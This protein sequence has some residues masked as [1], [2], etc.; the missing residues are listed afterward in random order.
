MDL[1]DDQ[2]AALVI[3]DI[4]DETDDEIAEALAGDLETVERWCTALGHHMN[5]LNG[6]F[7][8]R[9]ARHAA[10]REECWAGG[11]ARKAE[12]F[13]VDAEYNQWKRNAGKYRGFVQA[14]LTEAKRLRGELRREA[15]ESRDAALLRD[16]LAAVRQHRDDVAGD[17]RAADMALWGVLP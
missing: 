16:L 7:G 10:A 13:Q 11:D 4:R 5:T 17:A 1:D 8:D 2:F 9:K 3:A 15:A 12:W 6:Q 14:R